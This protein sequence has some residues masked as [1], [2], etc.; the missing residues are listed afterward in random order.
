MSQSGKFLLIIRKR[1][2]QKLGMALRDLSV[3]LTMSLE[4]AVETADSMKARGYGMRRRSTFHLFRFESRDARLMGLI[5]AAGGVCITARCLG[6]GHMEFYP[7]MTPVVTGAESIVLFVLFAG[8]VFLPG[9]LETKEA[10]KWRSYGLI[11]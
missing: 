1:I 6:H 8:L 11:G 3:L 9:I 2:L 4:N 10:V 7:R 5:L